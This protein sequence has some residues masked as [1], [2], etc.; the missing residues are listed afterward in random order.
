MSWRDRALVVVC[1]GIVKPALTLPLPWALHRQAFRLVMPRAP[2]ADGV[3]VT[4]RI[5]AG[6]PCHVF[7]PTDAAGSLL[8]LHGGG[9]VLGSARSYA[10]FALAL[11][12]RSGRRVI[13]PDYRL[14][15]EHPFPAGPDDCIA[16]ARELMKEGPFALGGDSAGG[17]LALTTLA[18]LL[19]DGTPPERVI[20][21]SPAVDLDPARPIPDARGEMIFPI[22]LLHRVAREYAG[23]ADPKDPR[24]SPIHAA[25]DSAPPI[26]IQCASGEVLEAD[27]DA[28]ARRL[29]DA[30]AHVEVQKTEGV[31][32]V[33]QLFVGRTPKAD[34]AV[35]AMATFLRNPAK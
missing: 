32:H 12:Q 25:F 10:L 11:A 1:R 16:V 21:A 34:R 3:T 17:T 20:L 29:I 24:V 6:V 8:W 23:D 26:L 31:P 4:T 27:S 13:M 33:W 2:R 18:D 5:I 15:P 7:S 22:A 30:G 28:I 19:S 35:D 9:F 14:A